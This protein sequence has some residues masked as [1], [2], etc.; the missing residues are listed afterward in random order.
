MYICGTILHFAARGSSCSHLDARL[1]FRTADSSGL[2]EICNEEG[3]WSISCTDIIG[4][5]EAK[6]ICRQL[7]FT[8]GFTNYLSVRVSQTDERP[9]FFGTSLSCSGNETSLS[10][11]LASPSPTP[12]IPVGGRRK[13]RSSFCFS[14]V[15][16][17]CGGIYG[18]SKLHVL[19]SVHIM[20]VNL[21][22]NSFMSS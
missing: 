22:I 13:R 9:M 6:V 18:I 19:V 11:C 4:V 17:R 7:G 8:P 3:N 1:V 12:G 20:A 15:R 21:I 16:L 2:V 5:N 14:Q 10:G